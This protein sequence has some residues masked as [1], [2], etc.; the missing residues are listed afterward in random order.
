M[1]NQ[2]TLLNVPLLCL[3]FSYV[4]E[5]ELNLLSWIPFSILKLAS[6]ASQFHAAHISHDYDLECFLQLKSYSGRLA[7]VSL[8]D[9]RF[10][11][12]L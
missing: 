11:N 6:A 7:A 4:I 5:N 1:T 9:F 8:T 3:Q 12:N 10:F 2:I